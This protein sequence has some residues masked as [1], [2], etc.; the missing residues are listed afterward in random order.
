[1]LRKL[2]LRMAI[3]LVIVSS[4]VLF[5]ILALLYGVNTRDGADWYNPRSL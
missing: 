1:M 2:V 3:T 4:L 5:D